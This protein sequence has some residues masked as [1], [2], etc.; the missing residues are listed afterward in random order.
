[1]YIIGLHPSFRDWAP[2]TL[3]EE[4]LQGIFC[5]INEITLGKHLECA[6]SPGEATRWLEGWKFQS[7]IPKLCRMEGGWWLRSSDN[8][9]QFNQLCLYS[10]DSIKTPKDWVER[11]SMLEHLEMWREQSSWK[12]HG[13]FL[14]SSYSLHRY[15]IHGLYL[16][17][18]HL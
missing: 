17:Y 2:K 3:S 10:E 6:L 9:H 12:R 13:R 16:T 11:M 8:G 14:L 4:G 7:P 15:L 18:T 1:M 5:Y